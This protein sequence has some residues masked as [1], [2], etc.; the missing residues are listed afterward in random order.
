MLLGTLAMHRRSLSGCF[1]L[2]SEITVTF[3]SVLIFPA[4][5]LRRSIF[6]SIR[7]PRED[8]GLPPEDL[9]SHLQF[10]LVLGM[11][12]FP[13]YFA[14]AVLQVEHL[15]LLHNIFVPTLI[16]YNDLVSKSDSLLP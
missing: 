9:R 15:A 7:S 11:T 2:S 6:L 16:P 5:E 13:S 14:P 4:R 8:A 10:S 12:S 1:C 3:S